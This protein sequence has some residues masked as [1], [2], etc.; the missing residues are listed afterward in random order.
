M[1]LC[2]TPSRNR[3]LVPLSCDLSPEIDLMA[4][5]GPKGTGFRLDTAGGCYK[6]PDW[7]SGEVTLWS[8]G[9]SRLT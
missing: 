1:S 6:V 5:T 8:N 4:H 7:Q 2:L 9:K 3:L